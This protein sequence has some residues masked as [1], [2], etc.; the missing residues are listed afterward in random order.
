MA[1]LSQTGKYGAINTTDTTTMGYC[2][3]KFMSESYTLEEETTCYGKIS[4][5]GGL[6]VKV[7]YM[8]CMKDNTKWYWEKSQQQNNIIVTTCK[9]CIHSWMS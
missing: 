6:D 8:N 7:Q 4:T 3:L 2:V 1:E 9:L 5:T